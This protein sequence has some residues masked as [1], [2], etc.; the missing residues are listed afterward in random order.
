MGVDEAGVGEAEGGVMA[1]ARRGRRAQ[2]TRA[3]EAAVGEAGGRGEAEERTRQAQARTRRQPFAGAQGLRS[4]T[5]IAISIRAM[6]KAARWG[7]CR[8]LGVFHDRDSGSQKVDEEKAT[9][10][11]HPSACATTKYLSTHVRLDLV[12]F[13]FKHFLP[14]PT[15]LQRSST[16][17]R[18]NRRAPVL[19]P[20]VA[21]LMYSESVLQEG[22]TTADHRPQID[23]LLFPFEVFPA[24][25]ATTWEVLPPKLPPCGG[26]ARLGE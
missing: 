4:G 20:Q 7:H 8:W 18:S 22:N 1:E 26:R 9:C 25:C 16:A 10:Q 3:D 11:C 12:I 24:L 17:R 19:P 14:S 2:T 21:T 6:G 5:G 13:D 23:L 15:N